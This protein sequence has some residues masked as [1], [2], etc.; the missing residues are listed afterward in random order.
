MENK[1]TPEEKAYIY[2]YYHLCPVNKTGKLILTPLRYMNDK[3]VAMLCY[4]L[5]NVPFHGTAQSEWVIKRESDRII[6]SHK[7]KQHSYHIDTGNGNIKIFNQ[8][9]L[10]NLGVD[11]FAM[12][13]YMRNY[14]DFPV[15][16]EPKHW[17]N[18]KTALQLGVAVPNKEPL[19]QLL[20]KVFSNNKELIADWKNEKYFTGVDLNN[21]YT[22]NEVYD[23][24]K[25][26]NKI[27]L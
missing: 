12:Q 17:A 22:Y 26:N 5:D 19:D 10:S 4:W 7:K 11:V 8:G 14:Y 23:E 18:G 15:F 2:Q 1:L 27:V 6:L 24:L 25:R 13:F 16:F 20:Y 21:V 9:K 3:D